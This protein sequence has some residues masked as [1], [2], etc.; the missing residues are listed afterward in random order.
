MAL[1]IPRS[2]PPR[3]PLL[4]Q[5]Q[6]YF[7]SHNLLSLSC[8]FKFASF[9]WLLYRG[10]LH[11]QPAKAVAAPRAGLKETCEKF[12]CTCTEAPTWSDAV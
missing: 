9:K 2:A 3:L 8:S 6:S 1:T 11:G 4:K 7:L 10:Q 5:S 12:P